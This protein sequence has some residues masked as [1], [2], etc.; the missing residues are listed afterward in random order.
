MYLGLS[1]QAPSTEKTI[2]GGTLPTLSKE[3]EAS[4]HFPHKHTP[5]VTCKKRKKK[6]RRQKKLSLR[7]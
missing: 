5:D 7:Q 3:R 6:P 4:Q 2:E 1:T